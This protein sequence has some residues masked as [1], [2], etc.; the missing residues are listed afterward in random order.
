MEKRLILFLVLSAVIFIGW[1]R[2]FAPQP[3]TPHP[4]DKAALTTPSPSASVAVTPESPKQPSSAPSTQPA[5]QVEPR[6]IK[7]KT[8]YWVATLSNK[9]GVVTE[10]TMTRF[11]DGKAIDPP[12]GVNLIS[13]ELSQK[14]GAPFRFY[15]PSDLSLESELNSAFYK[16]ENLPDQEVAISR[17]ENREIKFSYANNGVEATKAII[18][19]GQGENSSG[20]DFDFVGSVRRNGNP[21]QAYVVIGPNFG[22]QSV[23]EISTYKH[24]PQLTYAETDGGVVRKTAGSLKGG[25]HPTSLPVTWAA[26]DDNYFAM[27][28]VPPQAT[29]A[30]GLLNDKYVSV[31]VSLNDGAVNHVYAG[32]KD[33]SLLSQVSGEF[34]I[35]NKTPLED[36]VNYGIL[37]FVRV[38][39]KPIAQFMLKA[40]RA[41]NHVTHNF[42]W[43]IVILT[44]ALN[45]LFFPLRWRSSVIMKRAAA[46]APRMKDVQERMKK[47]DK[48][49]PRMLELQK[50]QIALMKEGNP[51][52][53]CLPLLLQMPFFIAVFAILTVS[54]EVRNAPFFG[55]IHDLSSMD[56]FYIL[57]IVMCVTMIAQTALTPSTAD[58]IQ[59]KVQYVM[60]LVLTVA[61]FRTA[62]A[63]LV[64]YWMVSNLVGVAQQYII[65]R[66][67]PT[68]PPAAATDTSG[69]DGPGPKSPKGRPKSPKGRKTKEALAN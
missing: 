69:S 9:G 67:N 16:V 55:W 56:P 58:P 20:F 21:V 33:L 57:P 2:F 44:V 42:G 24:A 35:S 26:V 32:P 22:D 15:I 30:V 47:L 25:A 59:K 40:L 48:N 43:S 23:K 64:L 53:G 45:M 14:I 60:P 49:D 36:I 6:Q 34:G 63:G 68:N 52:M 10:W 1:S 29:P 62:P 61:F 28:F 12:K 18:F 17:G 27:A 37:N 13:N 5:I 65:N 31:A 38:I 8:D 46:L 39:I 54:I 51:L 4:G 41:I 66:L 50:E 11:P 3:E 7:V 19:K